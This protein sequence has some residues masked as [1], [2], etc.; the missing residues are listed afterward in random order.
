MIRKVKYVFKLD[1][2]RTNFVNQVIIDLDQD[3]SYVY[4]YNLNGKSF[5]NSL[6]AN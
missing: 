5:S 4:F 1:Y 3:K 2:F 6:Q